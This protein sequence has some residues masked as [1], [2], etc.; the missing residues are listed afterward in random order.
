[1]HRHPAS[2]RRSSSDAFP[3]RLAA[4]VIAGVALRVGY[5]LLSRH[6]RP[7][8]DA[9]FFFVM[10]QLLAAG[11]GFDNSVVYHLSGDLVPT[12]LHPPL[13]PLLLAA[14]GKLGAGGYVEQRMVL[15]CLLGA[16]TITAV[17]LLGRRI[18]GP[19]AGLLAAA[20]A[21]VDPMLVGAD[22]ALMSEAVFGVLVMC[23]MLVAYAMLER[24]GIWRAALLG[25]LI[26]A[27]TLTRGEGVLMLPLL[28][29][30]LA[31]RRKPL[32]APRRG[33]QLAVAC[34]VCLVVIAPWSVRNWNTF[35]RFVPVSN[36]DGTLI[37]GANCDV[38]Y[39]GPA[40]GSWRLDCIPRRGDPNEAEAAR[41]YRDAGT[42]YAG[43]HLGRL[44]VV[45]A[46]RAGRS[47]GLF[48]IR[49]EVRHTE[50]RAAALTAAGLATFLLLL[51]FAAAGAVSLRRRREPL[52]ILAAPAVI[53]A[54]VTLFGYGSP[55]FRHPVDLVV[56]VLAAV[57]LDRWWASREVRDRQR[58]C[59]ASA[60]AGSATASPRADLG[61]R[62]KR[63]LRRRNG[64]STA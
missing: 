12:A 41:V 4:V 1:M 23:A 52:F 50:G 56:V 28:A 15:G 32:S 45:L 57:A 55:R 54:A 3:Q 9:D 11:H 36:N 37:A 51:P 48:G 58:G 25:A 43:N 35:D 24:P 2:A 44:P 62:P 49:W 27:A 64:R 6:L 18:G 22:A 17:A 34:G 19:R 46:A 47:L 59:G 8:G 20:I 60:G 30:P 26:G 7:A 42:A 10:G 31:V 13:F 38:T 53:A 14:I 40:L 5:V 63:F 21:A 29:L 33:A 16:G 61:A 39:Y